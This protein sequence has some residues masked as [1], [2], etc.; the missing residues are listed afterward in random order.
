M[1]AQC[2]IDI[3]AVLSELGA[4]EAMLLLDPARAVQGNFPPLAMLLAGLASWEHIGSCYAPTMV[5]NCSVKKQN[6]CC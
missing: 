6:V 2:E 3:G 4:E 1:G 5:V